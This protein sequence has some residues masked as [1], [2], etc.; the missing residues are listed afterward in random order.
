[1]PCFA[2]I[3]SAEAPV[4][5]PAL[6][7]TSGNYN[8]TAGATGA[9]VAWFNSPYVFGMK[10]NA[11]GT[12]NVATRK[13]LASDAPDPISYAWP[14][15]YAVDDSF[16][17]SYVPKGSSST[18][19]LRV[20]GGVDAQ[21]P[22]NETLV[23]NGSR[24]L[25]VDSD[26]FQLF[27]TLYDRN[28]TVVVPRA[29]IRTAEYFVYFSSAGGKFLMTTTPKA[30]YNNGT[31]QKLNGVIIDNDGKS[32]VVPLPNY[33]PT[34][35]T[36]VA[37]NGA[38]YLLVWQT[39]ALHVVAQHFS[40]SGTPSSDLFAV[41]ARTSVGLLSPVAAWSGSEYVVSWAIGDAFTKTGRSYAH[42]RGTTTSDAADAPSQYIGLM[43][44]P[45]GAFG[46]YANSDGILVMQRL[47]VADTPHPFLLSETS[48]FAVDIASADLSTTGVLWRES[49]FLMFGR[50][51]ASGQPLDGNGIVVGA[52]YDTA[53]VVA[54]PL[55]FLVVRNHGLSIQA[56]LIS[57]DGKPV[58][59]EKTIF[60]AGPN[61]YL[62]GFDAVWNGSSFTLLWSTSAGIDGAVILPSGDV[63]GTLPPYAVGPVIIAGGSPPLAVFGTGTLKGK[64]LDAT[65]SFTMQ[66][67]GDLRPI[68]I[69]TSGKDYL[70]LAGKAN[71]NYGVYP[72]VTTFDLLVTRFDAHG[73]AVD[74][75]LT[76]ISG[77]KMVYGQFGPAT[78]DNVS[79][80]WDGNNYR[81]AWLDDARQLVVATIDHAQLF[82]N[83]L[84][85]KIGVPMPTQA[86]NARIAS[87]GCGRLLV[88]YDRAAS[89]PWFGQQERAFV[90]DLDVPR[91]HAAGR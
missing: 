76:L 36:A 13:L 20:D 28:L 85:S 17:V 67:G 79:A 38:E 9:Y 58:G 12:P 34:Y 73:V 70:L 86:S 71:T 60:T 35:G 14:S 46:V 90:R 53:R 78:L 31:P 62:V 40:P 52:G 44:S 33:I 18:R 82:C 29:A 5:T 64:F 48:Q 83:C 30:S 55:D 49:N 68:A 2:G 11:D 15:V 41:A 1:V 54:G 89:D 57:R 16:Y 59:A 65:L 24:F 66:S 77:A 91:H 23:W 3:I 27:A 39:D 8:V 63:G 22:F 42:V 87:P 25:A 80:V 61:N 84:T 4:T 6:L 75:P 21:L 72:P 50:L 19:V 51:D 69:A 47:D 43:S 56:Q 37:T 10:L 45:N 74:G 32:S 7:P 88:L 81:V 26:G